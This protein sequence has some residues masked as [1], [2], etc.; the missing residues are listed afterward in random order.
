MAGGF[1][2]RPGPSVIPAPGHDYPHR[3]HAV[4][5]ACGRAIS[6]VG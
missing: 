1:R 6:S 4:R 3:P 2:Q 5:I